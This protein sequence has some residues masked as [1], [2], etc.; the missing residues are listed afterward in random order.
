MTPE[1][2]RRKSKLMLRIQKALK[3][4]KQLRNPGANKSTFGLEMAEPDDDVEKF[5]D[6]LL[7]KE[8]TDAG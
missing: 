2:R 4:N 5:W 3:E 7:P 1:Q 6:D 8:E